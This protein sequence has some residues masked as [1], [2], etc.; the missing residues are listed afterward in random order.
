MR[1]N[2]RGDLGWGLSRGLFVA[3]A[4]SLLAAI[5]FTGA[6]LTNEDLG[7]R[8]LAS[9]LGYLSAGVLGGTLVGAMRPILQH[10]WGSA[11]AGGI[12]APIAFI[13]VFSGFEEGV[14]WL[15]EDGLENVLFLVVVALGAGSYAGWEWHRRESRAPRPRAVHQ[16]NAGDDPAP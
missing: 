10:S 8:Y 11:L 13:A 12:I 6:R 4:C 3:L 7:I 2:I 14:E 16:A 9:V 5:G 1:R 15:R